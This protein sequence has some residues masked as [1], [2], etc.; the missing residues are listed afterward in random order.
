[1]YTNFVSIDPF[2]KNCDCWFQVFR[3]LIGLEKD[4]AGLE[5][6]WG[7]F[8]DKVISLAFAGSGAV[9]ADNVK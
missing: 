3:I 2:F 6:D 7:T 5:Q 8:S 9:Q 1:M 4:Q